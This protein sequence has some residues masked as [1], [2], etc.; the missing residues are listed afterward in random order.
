[1]GDARELIGAGHF[2][3]RGRRRRKLVNGN[4]AREVVHLMGKVEAVE[5]LSRG[6]N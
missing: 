5:A 2:G 6:C 3:E 1:M 4:W